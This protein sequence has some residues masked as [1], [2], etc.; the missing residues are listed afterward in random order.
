MVYPYAS[1]G[2]Y[3]QLVPINLTHILVLGDRD[4]SG[5][6]PSIHRFLKDFIIG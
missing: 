5:E 1:S 3:F 2:K 6:F 4:A